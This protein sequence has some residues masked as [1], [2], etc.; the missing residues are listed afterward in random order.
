MFMNFNVQNAIY[1][2][3]INH[4]VTGMKKPVVSKRMRISAH[5]KIVPSQ[6]MSSMQ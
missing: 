3:N 2:S 1:N 6:V 5:L 4:F